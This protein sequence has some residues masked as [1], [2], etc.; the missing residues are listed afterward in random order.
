[1]NNQM[2]FE[3]QI[4]EIEILKRFVINNIRNPA[5]SIQYFHHFAHV[6]NEAEE[7]QVIQ[8]L[9]DHGHFSISNEQ[10]T[11]LEQG[12]QPHYFDKTKFIELPIEDRLYRHYDEV[13]N[14]IRDFESYIASDDYANPLLNKLLDPTTETVPLNSTTKDKLLQSFKKAQT[15]YQHAFQFYARHMDCRSANIPDK[16]SEKIKKIQAQAYKDLEIKEMIRVYLKPKYKEHVEKYLSPTHK[17]NIE[18]HALFDTEIDVEYETMILPIIIEIYE[19][20]QRNLLN[21]QNAFKNAQNKGSYCYTYM[22]R[23]KKVKDIFIK[24]G[25]QGAIHIKRL[26]DRLEGCKKI[27]EKLQA[28]DAIPYIHKNILQNFY[29]WKHQIKD[30]NDENLSLYEKVK[31]HYTVERRNAYLK[32]NI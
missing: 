9:L 5:I 17:K 6:Q 15:A 2:K 32:T 8:S 18:A 25:I 21:K 1:M 3:K 7:Q 24:T 11:W 4:E 27:L 30:Q 12:L 20:K 19:H 26:D 29:Q 31:K 13:L 23:K 22:P 16:I 28:E 10:K 14:A